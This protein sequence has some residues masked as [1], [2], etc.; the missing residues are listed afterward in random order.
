VVD[1]L[2]SSRS[3]SSRRSTQYARAPLW[4][5]A[6][7]RRLPAALA[8]RGEPF[9]GTSFRFMGKWVIRRTIQGRA[10]SE[11]RYCAEHRPFL[12]R[13]GVIAVEDYVTGLVKDGER[14]EISAHRR[15]IFRGEQLV[16]FIEVTDSLA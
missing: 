1:E 5:I 13:T 16:G 3:L 11:P 4:L 2:S 10:A 7:L 6:R 8:V 9:L 12:P 15:Q 14:L